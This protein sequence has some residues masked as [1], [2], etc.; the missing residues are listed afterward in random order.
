LSGNEAFEQHYQAHRFSL[1]LFVAAF[2]FSLTWINRPEFK[3]V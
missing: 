1:V 3:P 2:A